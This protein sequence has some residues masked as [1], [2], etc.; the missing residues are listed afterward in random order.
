MKARKREAVG[1]LPVSPAFPS[2]IIGSSPALASKT[3][4]DAQA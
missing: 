2:V 3:D 4:G 1:I